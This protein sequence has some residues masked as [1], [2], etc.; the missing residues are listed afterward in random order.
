MEKTR[1]KF[2]PIDFFGK[3]GILIIL[4]A[5]VI[6]FAFANENFLT[7]ENI[8]NILRQT[9]IKGFICVGM[10][11]V[12]ITGGIDLSVGSICGVCSCLMAYLL[13]WNVPYAFAFIIYCTTTCNI[14]TC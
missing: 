12:I 3:Y 5:M 4:I 8:G 2:N 6:A 10:A 1:K 9:A 14:A 11:M 13:L 7:F